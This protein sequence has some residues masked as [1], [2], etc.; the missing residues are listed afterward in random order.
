MFMIT[1]K[2]VALV[3][4][5]GC[6]KST[7]IQLVQRF[8]DPIEGRVLIDGVDLKDLNVG[9]LRDNVGIVGQ[10]PALFEMTIREN[11]R[12]GR[13]AASD[14]EIEEATR[15]SN[16]YNFIMALPEKFN[17]NVGERGASLSG[18][19]KQR[20]A[21]ARALVRNPTILL[22]DEATSAL[23]NESESIV[24]DALEKASAGRTTLVVAHRL[25]T[26]R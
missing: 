21:I 11:I 18:G 25:S 9:W 4:T 14:A 13:P 17:T 2:T 19:Q 6:G 7:C 26:I 24:Q 5:S 23:D 20:I 16:A 15:K 12:M 3:G 22:L 8:Y 10:E 1:G